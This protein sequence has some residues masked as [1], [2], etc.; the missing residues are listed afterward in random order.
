M[1]VA[2]PIIKRRNTPPSVTACAYLRASTWETVFIQYSWR[3]PYS[4]TCSYLK[5]AMILYFP[6]LHFNFQLLIWIIISATA[7]PL[8]FPHLVFL[9]DPENLVLPCVLCPFILSDSS[10]QHLLPLAW[11]VHVSVEGKQQSWDP[12]HPVNPGGSG[13]SLPEMYEWLLVS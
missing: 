9:C 1:N 7:N 11:Y 13:V 5:L 3:A 8:C 12:V 4:G 6:L 2:C 10:F